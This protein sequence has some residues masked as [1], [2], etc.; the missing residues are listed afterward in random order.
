[1]VKTITGMALIA[2]I[3]SSCSQKMMPGD[4]SAQT[5]GQQLSVA[6]YEANSNTDKNPPVQVKT[7][8][9]DAQATL[10]AK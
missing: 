2:I 8:P 6:Q 10:L 4:S 5:G 1:M 3:C 7:Q 9:G